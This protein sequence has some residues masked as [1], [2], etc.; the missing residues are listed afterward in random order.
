MKKIDQNVTP[1]SA[2]WEDIC[3]RCSRCCYE[4]LD[5]RG[6]IFY[7]TKPCPHLD[8]ELKR[9]RIYSQRSELYP[10]CATLTPAIVAAGYLPADC[11][12]VE[13]LNDYPSPVIEQD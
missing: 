10:D 9:C 7:T 1:G 6:K 12:Y 5:Y 4:K 2:E 8:T 11:P 13:H 3:Q